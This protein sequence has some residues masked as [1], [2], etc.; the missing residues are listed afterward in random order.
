MSSDPEP[1]RLVVL[2]G[3]RQPSGDPQL[4]SVLERSSADAWEHDPEA[5]RRAFD[6]WRIAVAMQLPAPLHEALA[7]LQQSRTARRCA[8]ITRSIDGLLQKASAEHVIELQ[9]SLFRLRCAH[10]PRHPRVGIFGAQR[11][12]RGCGICGA[13]LRPDVS[14]AGTLPTALQ[15]ARSALAG[16]ELALLV[17]ASTDPLVEALPPGVQRLELDPEPA[18]SLV[19]QLAW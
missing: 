13:P 6:A 2:C 18:V 10:D 15:A 7:R 17:G 1:P 14:L 16:C 11:C 3:A 5:V 8:L 19:H 9:G 4:S 12:D